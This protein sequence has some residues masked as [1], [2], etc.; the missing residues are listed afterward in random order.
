VSL[1]DELVNEC[2]E[3]CA[4]LISDF[5]CFRLAETKSQRSSL[6][7]T[8]TDLDSFNFAGTSLQEPIIT[9]FNHVILQK[10]LG[11]SEHLI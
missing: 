11:A 7:A 1:R 8:T 3:A 5:N 9:L 6:P 10:V 4:K 2:R